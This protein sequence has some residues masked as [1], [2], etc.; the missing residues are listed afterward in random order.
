MT[1]PLPNVNYKWLSTRAHPERCL[2]SQVPGC[3]LRH[4]EAGMWASTVIQGES[5]KE[6]LRQG[7]RK[8]LH[9]IQ[10]ENETETE[11]EKTVPVTCLVQPGTTEYKVSFFVP[12]KHQNSPPEPT[13]PEVFLELRKGAA[14]FVRSFGGFAS[15]EKFSKEAK[16]LAD[17]LQKEGQSFH[18]DFYY[19]AGYNHPF[20]LFNRHNEVWYFKKEEIEGL[21][22]A[23]NFL[24]KI[25]KLL[26]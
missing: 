5:Q 22:M 14:I 13:D 15:V 19:T 4:Y 23:K 26:V 16:A 1:W 20:T 2:Y 10:G 18:S 21:W 3:E 8:L 24:G 25:G 6:A 11:I 12:K 7:V 9:Y 17:T